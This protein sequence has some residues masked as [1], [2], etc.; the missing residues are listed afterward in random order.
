MII[1]VT[2][3]DIDEGC[4]ED[5]NNCP[6]ARAIARQVP[7]VIAESVLVDSCDIGFRVGDTRIEVSTPGVVADWIVVFDETAIHRAIE[8]TPDPEP[9]EFELGWSPAA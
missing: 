5:A 3:C 8:G 9:F 2:Q 7:G 4:R 6:V 1:Q